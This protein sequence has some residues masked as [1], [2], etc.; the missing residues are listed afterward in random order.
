MRADEVEIMET[1]Y[2]DITL[3]DIRTVGIEEDSVL[4]MVYR[5]PPR[6]HSSKAK[7]SS[8]SDVA[9]GLLGKLAAS[10]KAEA[11]PRG[12]R[13]GSS[14]SGA[15]PRAEEGPRADER[16]EDAHPEHVDVDEPLL[17]VEAHALHDD[18]DASM[19]GG[20]LGE[21]NSDDETDLDDVR[22]EVVAP[23]GAAASSGAPAAAAA[24]SGAPAAAAA[25]AG[26]QDVG[27]AVRRRL[28]TPMQ[29]EAF[30]IIARL[31]AWAMK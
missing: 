15:R 8:L 29:A 12:S 31:H 14:S 20:S 10:R 13:H 9:A 7:S 4:P 1:A 5:V 11:A 21:V 6:K 28:V 22:A 2:V 19:G 16:G 27:R 23:A 24:S 26:R 3:I 30:V 17:F 25:P 18:T